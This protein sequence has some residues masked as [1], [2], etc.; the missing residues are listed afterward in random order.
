MVLSI[1]GVLGVY[2]PVEL[3][4]HNGSQSNPTISPINCI[5]PMECAR[6]AS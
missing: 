2:P 6:D 4:F 1:A 5:G 3:D